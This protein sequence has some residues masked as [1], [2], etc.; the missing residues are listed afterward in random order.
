MSA[1]CA[2]TDP[3]L[4]YPKKGG[5]GSAA[6]AV[7]RLCDVRAE[8]LTDALASGEQHG[9]WGGLSLGQRRRHPGYVPPPAGWPT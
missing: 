5:T 6:K 8:C 7:C 2:Q 9:V 1:L 3:E 4:F